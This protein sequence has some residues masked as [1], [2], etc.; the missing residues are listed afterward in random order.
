MVGDISRN[1]AKLREARLRAAAQGA[2]LLMT[3]ELYLCAYPPEDLVMKPSFQNSL[4]AAIEA[5]A[6]ETAD[7]VLR[8]CWDRRGAKEDKLYN[9][10]LLLDKGIIVAKIF[11]HDLPNYGPFDD[12]RVFT[13]SPLPEPCLFAASNWEC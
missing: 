4:R 13:A 11:K 6:A 7:V 3:S 2:D 12:K 5:L 9:A 8:F 10:A 1:I